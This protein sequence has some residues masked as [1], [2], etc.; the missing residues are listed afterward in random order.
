MTSHT[1]FW[2]AVLGM[3]R[4]YMRR[5]VRDEHL[6][7]DLAQDTLVKI[8]A[9]TSSAPEDERLT[10]WMI[11]IARNTLTD[12]YRSKPRRALV[13]L[14]EAE[15]LSGPEPEAEATTGL[16]LCLRPMIGRLAQPYRQAL[17]LTEYEGLSQKE[18]ADRVGI[19]LSGAKSRVQRAREQVR[20][21]LL[22]CCR[23]DLDGRGGVVDYERTERS[24]RYCQGAEGGAEQCK[25]FSASTEASS[26]P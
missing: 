2:T 1:E 15:G 5:R 22:D 13:T 11:R 14:Q 4:R 21:L 10:A 24:E 26:R 25:G 12:F 3:L 23:V 17:E 6:A 16:T 18:L 7:D 8:H 20:E 19:S 9:A